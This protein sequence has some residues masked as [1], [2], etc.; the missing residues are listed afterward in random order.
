MSTLET[1]FNKNPK[2]SFR[3]PGDILAMNFDSKDDYL[4]NGMFG[5]GKSFTIVGPPGVGKSFL[6]LQFA[7]CIITGR[8]FIGLPVH[9]QDLTWMI[10]QSQNYNKRL[11]SDFARL[12]S[13]LGETDWKRFHDRVFIHTL[14]GEQD[15]IFTLNASTIT[16]IASAIGDIKPGV[17][18]F[19]PLHDFAAGNLNSASGMRDTCNALKQLSV[20]GNP[21]ASLVLLHHSISGRQGIKMAANI[22]DQSSFAGG[23]KTALLSFTRG[24][25]NIVPAD[26]TDKGKLLVACPKNSDNPEFEPFGIIR[27]AQGIFEVDSSFSLPAFNA[28]IAGESLAVHKPTPDNIAALVRHIPLIKKALVGKVME[29]FGYRLSNA[30]RVIKDAEEAGAIKRNGKMEY[31]A[32]K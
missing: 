22:F 32:T 23:S 11:D 26:E 7:A 15:L 31:T 28:A 13:W 1:E 4:V 24:Q 29:E 18:V 19:D 30:Y 8:D 2:L 3:Q 9:R 12:R 6:S 10:F 14:E 25:L 16:R 17:V 21:H 5:K 27:N 20:Y